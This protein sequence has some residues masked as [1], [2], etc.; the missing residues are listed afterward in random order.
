[1]AYGTSG[2]ILRVDLTRSSFRSENFDEEFYRLYPGGKALAGY[3]LLKELAP[4]TDALAPENILVIANGLLTGAPFSASTRFTMAAR[5]PLTG[6]YGESEAGGYWGPELKT[7]GY[8]AIVIT[9]RAE[10]P[11]YLMIRDDKVELRDARALWGCEPEEVQNRIRAEM[12]DKHVRV[13]QIGMGGE[14]CV[15]YAAVSNE[16]RHY[17]GRTGMGAVMG[18]KNLKAIAVRGTGH[19]RDNAHDIEPITEIARSLSKRVKE[20]PQAW[21]LQVKGTPDLVGAFNAGGFLPTRNFRQ[22]VFEGV[23]NIKWEA[24]E[25]Q[26]LSAR[27][28]C[29]ACAV[30]CKREVKVDDRYQVSDAYGG[31]EYETV[32]GF[33][34]Y[35]G[36]DDLQAIA[37]ANELC[38]RYTLDTIS[39][40]STIAFAMECFEHG[41]IG[42][43][44]T[45]G[46]DLRF[47]NAEAVLK[48]I[49]LIARREG[50]GN[51]LAEGSKRAAEVIGGDAH[52]FSIQVKGMELAM[53]DPRGKVGVGIGYAIG[54]Y[55]GDHLYSVHDPLVANPESITFKGAEPLSV[56]ALPP[57]ELGAAKARNYAILENWSSFG[58]VVGLCYFGPAPRS[59]MQVDEVLT[60]VRA[61]TGWNELTIEDLLRIGER[62]TNLARAFNVLNGFS[63]KDDTLPERMFQPL[64][65]GP[66]AGATMPREEF[67]QTM[68]EVYRLK[69]WSLDTTAPTRGRLHELGI[70]WVADL[71]GV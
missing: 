27:K 37:K 38:D 39:T 51:L 40:S 2:K 56:A 4:G 34:G 13:L 29:Y 58:K 3:L 68:D 16:L 55:G 65:N 15:R 67:Q 69:G 61:A 7:A 46:L 11:T 17:N 62:A 10:H 25:K 45:G 28:T 14:N 22:G 12:A 23:D 31:P 60:A 47:G 42:L 1:M 63:R 50:I 32:E 57:R 71:L 33:G 30:R 35:C 66:M 8:E 6:T 26:I 9:G 59:F 18:S 70:E 48:A 19:Y 43:K 52:L 36:V 44:D 64:E 5:S 54:E 53:H 24:Y 49:E 20:H 21:D 41:L